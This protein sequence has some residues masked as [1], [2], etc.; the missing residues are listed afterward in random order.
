MHQAS[1]DSPLAVHA[2]AASFAARLAPAGVFVLRYGLVFLLG[3]IG[4]FKFFPWEAAGIKPLIAN[5]PFMSW[6]LPVFG[7]RGASGFIGAVEISAAL[8]IATRRF[9]PRLSMYGSLI[10][11]LTFVVTLSFLF[12]TPT[13][14]DPKNMLNGFLLKDLILLGAALYTAGEAW[15]ASIARP[16]AR[17]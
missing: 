6:M 10:A 17:A 9:A 4:A 5:S 7:E 15:A 1:I 8:L 13:A 3:L 12:T 11:V 14:L 2:S 16:V